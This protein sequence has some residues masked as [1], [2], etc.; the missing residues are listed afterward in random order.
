M[1]YWPNLSMGHLHCSAGHVQAILRT[2]SCRLSLRRAPVTGRAFCGK[3]W[4]LVPGCTAALLCLQRCSCLSKRGQ[5]RSLAALHSCRPPV[6]L[7]LLLDL[8]AVWL[9]RCVWRRACWS[10]Q[11]EP[12]DIRRRGL[13]RGCLG[14]RHSLHS[15]QI[16]GWQ[17]YSA[18]HGVALLRGRLALLCVGCPGQGTDVCLLV[19]GCRVWGI[20]WWLS[21]MRGAL[22]ILLQVSCWLF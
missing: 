3:H 21:W 14:Q 13:Q 15:W 6:C 12:H 2:I 1:H 7:L 16:T 19:V 17:R 20:G 22:F 4:V 8:R 18:F 5:G 11:R 10:L 9:G